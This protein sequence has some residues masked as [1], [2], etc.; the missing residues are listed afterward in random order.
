MSRRTLGS[1]SSVINVGGEEAL[2][3]RIGPERTHLERQTLRMYERREE[4]WRPL[5]RR[6]VAAFIRLFLLSMVYR[7]NGHRHGRQHPFTTKLLKKALMKR[8]IPF[9]YRWLVFTM[10]EAYWPITLEQFE[11]LDPYV[12]AHLL[13]THRDHEWQ[14]IR[15][16]FKEVV[17]QGR[18]EYKRLEELE[19]EAMEAVRWCLG[20]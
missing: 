2:Q 13:Q 3:R 1:L 9:I 17:R 14:T 20:R 7:E 19:K 18:E 16:F 12:E 10:D 8:V 11:E 5:N 15:Y 4:T 6:R